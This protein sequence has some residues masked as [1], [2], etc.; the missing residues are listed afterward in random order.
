M[1]AFEVDDLKSS[2]PVLSLK[3]DELIPNPFS[4]QK[5]SAA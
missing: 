5:L 4:I 3:I 1:T 2:V